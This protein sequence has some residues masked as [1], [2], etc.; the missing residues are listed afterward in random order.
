[1]SSKI[2]ELEIEIQKLESM[3]DSMH[4]FKKEYQK[5]GYGHNLSDICAEVNEVEIVCDNIRSLCTQLIENE[6]TR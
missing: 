2:Y 6:H 4:N 3:A 5:S 1:M